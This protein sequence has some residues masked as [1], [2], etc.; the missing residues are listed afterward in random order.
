MKCMHL[1][2]ASCV[3]SLELKL[4]W[5]RLGTDRMGVATG[6]APKYAMG[7]LLR[8]SHVCS[9]CHVEKMLTETFGALL[10]TGCRHDSR[11]GVRP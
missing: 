6:L 7:G 11:V 4:S 2:L 9:S 1:L 10:D 3:L 5:S 8:G